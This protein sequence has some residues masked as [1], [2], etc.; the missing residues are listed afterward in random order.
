[1]GARKILQKKS[2][3]IA[4]YIVVVLLFIVWVG[5]LDV[6]NFSDQIKYRMKIR[7]MKDEK[8]YY[9]DKIQEDSTRLHELNTSDENLEKYAREKY[10]M[11][12]KGEEIFLVKKQK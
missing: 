4:K 9:L 8:A 3:K 6:H 1:M 5:F 11:K 7:E 2:F 12:K 10:Y